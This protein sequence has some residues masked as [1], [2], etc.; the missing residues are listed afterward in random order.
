MPR[1]TLCHWGGRLLRR[2]AFVG[3]ALLT[4]ALPVGAAEVLIFSKTAGYRHASI[5]A[6]VAA[7]SELAEAS[8]LAVRATEDARVFDRRGLH[9]VKVVV[10]ALTTGDVLDEG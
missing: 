10:F 2:C 1:D 5:P 7:V 3:V 6:A 4:S 9:G 8:G